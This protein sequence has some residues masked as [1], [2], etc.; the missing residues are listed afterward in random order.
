MGFMLLG[1]PRKRGCQRD[2]RFTNWNQNTAS[3]L[4][5]VK[6]SKQDLVLGAFLKSERADNK[7]SRGKVVQQ[8]DGGGGDV[9]SWGFQRPGCLTVRAYCC[10][11][12]VEA[13]AG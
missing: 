2:L 7:N 8:G 6:L 3:A 11:L 1:S 10:G 13:G 4:T 12:E 5:K 9:C